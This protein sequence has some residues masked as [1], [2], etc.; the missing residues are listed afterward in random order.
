MEVLRPPPPPGGAAATD[1]DIFAAAG[2]Q[3]IFETLAKTAGSACAIIIM[4]G[5]GAD[6]TVEDAAADFEQR[7]SAACAPSNRDES[8]W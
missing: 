8:R 7:T 6:G 2:G 4:S 1:A 3:S 5:P